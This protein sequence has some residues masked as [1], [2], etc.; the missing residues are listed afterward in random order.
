MKK[1][2][3]N[4]ISIK[5]KIY[6]NK[7]DIIDIEHLK[8][9]FTYNHDDEVFYTYEEFDSYITV[10]SNAYW[11]LD[12]EQAEDLRNFNQFVDAIV[13]NG[14]LRKEQEEA[15]TK[16][17]VNGRARSGIFQAKPGFGKTYTACALIAKTQTPTLILVHTKLLY[18]QW[19]KELTSQLPDITI[20]KIGDGSFSVGDVTVAIYKTVSNNLEKL[21]NSF[22]MLIVDECHKAPAAMFF[23]VANNLNAKVKIGLSAT[24]RRKDG[25]HVF[26]PD[27]FTQFKVIAVDSRNLAIPS[28]KI[29]KSDFK[30][31]LLDP[32]RE[33]AKTMNKLCGDTKYQNFVAEHA[34]NAIKNGRCPLIIGERV[35]FLKD[36]EKLIPNSICV[37]GDSPEEV[38]EDALSGL[39][40]KYKAI[41]TTKLFDEGVSCHRLDTLMLVCPSNNSIQLEQR[42]G[43]IERE[44]PDSKSPLIMDF[45]LVG[46]I[47]TR[48]QLNRMQWYRG[49]NYNIL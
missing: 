41:L 10:P 17:L 32:K 42:V 38:R 23:N 29:I 6:I 13:F 8:S 36:L 43:R 30:F 46:G 39:G 1:A 40:T 14:T 18:N 20:G 3:V 37:I 26:L 27:L 48:Q 9:L 28:V 16:F 25:K 15:V 11:K 22:G 2:I 33:W 47:V 45:W 34:I 5:E 21:Q 31:S 24:P 49:Q 4:L 19:I 35:Q 7:T 12:F 44:H